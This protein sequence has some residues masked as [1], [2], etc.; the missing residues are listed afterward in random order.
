M[1]R[2]LAF[3]AAA[4]VWTASGGVRAST[5]ETQ[6]R[7]AAARPV[8]AQSVAQ[9]PPPVTASPPSADGE[10]MTAPPKPN[11]PSPRQPAPKPEPTPRHRLDLVLLPITLLALVAAV[12]WFARRRRPASKRV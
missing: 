11:L 12:R 8:P 6:A 10:A 9:P 2:L 5:A 3:A 1:R 4:I 7:L